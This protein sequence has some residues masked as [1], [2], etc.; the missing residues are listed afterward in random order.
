MCYR[1]V[2]DDEKEEKEIP[3]VPFTVN[4]D[5]QMD[6]NNEQ[7]LH[8]IYYVIRYYIGQIIFFFNLG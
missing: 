5:L 3:N 6:N 7:I 4:K 1:F 8:C 2:N